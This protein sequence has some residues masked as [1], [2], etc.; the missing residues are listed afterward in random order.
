MEYIFTF[1]VLLSVLQ[2]NVTHVILNV[3]I[4]TT[5]QLESGRTHTGRVHLKVFGTQL[6]YRVDSKGFNHK[7]SLKYVT[8]TEYRQNLVNTTMLSYVFRLT[9]FNLSLNKVQQNFRPFR[10]QFHG[11]ESDHSPKNDTGRIF[12]NPP[13]LCRLK[14]TVLR[15]IP[16]VQVRTPSSGGLDQWRSPKVKNYHSV[17]FVDLNLPRVS[18]VPS[19]NLGDDRSLKLNLFPGGYL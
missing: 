6:L 14:E 7:I 4:T 18:P 2:D 5:T 19:P 10:F 12:F 13:V 15:N 8:D 17:T 11:D 16:M 1:D 3:L 9:K